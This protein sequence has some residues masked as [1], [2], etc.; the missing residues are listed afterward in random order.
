M[1]RGSVA[2]MVGA[3]LSFAAHGAYATPIGMSPAFDINGTPLPFSCDPATNECVGSAL[4][5]GAYDL[6]WDLTLISDPSITGN[7][8]LT[9]LAPTTQTFILT[10]TLPTVP[11]GPSLSV[12][13]YSGAG[14]LIDANGGGATLTDDGSAIYTAMIDGSSVHTL[15][16]PS[17]SFSVPVN[18]NG[19][20]GSVPIGMV[21]F[22][23]TILGQ[24][25]NSSIGIRDQFR[26]TSGDEVQLP[27][28]FTANPATVPEVPEPATLTLLGTGLLAVARR[29]IAP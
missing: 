19:G 9:N 20:G 7:F 26:L 27:I 11:V 2:I 6:T 17:Q 4:V 22:G 13:G 18:P 15:L 21:S 10:V 12:S 14:S 28:G 24:S 3:F 29:R 25:A 5:P 8:S 16:D 1:K 23:P